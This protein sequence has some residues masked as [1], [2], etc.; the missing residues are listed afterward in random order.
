MRAGF[1]CAWMEEF[2]CC[3]MTSNFTAF[4]IIC[5]LVGVK[6]YEECAENGA[7][8][9]HNANISGVLSICYNSTWRLVCDDEWDTFDA[10][11]VCKQLGLEYEDETPK[12]CPARG[13]NVTGS[14]LMNRVMCLGTE[15]S[16][17]MCE[18][19]HDVTDCVDEEAVVVECKDVCNCAE[20]AECVNNNGN[21]SCICK[22]G[23]S[24][25]GTVCKD[26]N[27]CVLEIHNCAE[28]AKCI[29]TPGSF[30]CMC[31]YGYV[32]NGTHCESCDPDNSPIGFTGNGTYCEDI[33]E[34]DLGTH[35]CDEN[36][37]CTNVPGSFL[38]VCNNGYVGDGTF[39]IDSLIRLA[40]NATSGFVEVYYN[41]EWRS[42]CDDY[43]SYNDAN[44]ACGQLGFLPFC[45]DA[46]TKGSFKPGE[47]AKY[48][49]DDVQC[50]GDEK[51]LFDCPHN[52]VATHNCGPK[53]RAGVHCLTEDDI[54]I[55]LM[56]NDTSGI[57]EVRIR[58]EWRAVCDNAWSD[59]DAKVACRELGF[60]F[61]DAKAS[62]GGHGEGVYWLN[63]VKC[64]G[65]EESLFACSHSGKGVHNCGP[66]KRAGVICEASSTSI[67]LRQRKQV[68]TDGECEVGS[69]RLV[70]EDFSSWRVGEG[71]VE[72][73]VMGRW[74]AVCDDGWDMNATMVVCREH[75]M[76]TEETVPIRR[77]YQSRN[78]SLVHYW[79]DDIQ[80]NGDEESLLDCQHAALGS[81]DCGYND[82][83]SV[84]CQG[85]AGNET[86]AVKGT[87]IVGDHKHGYEDITD[88]AIGGVANVVGDEISGTVLFK[89][90]QVEDGTVFMVDVDILGLDARERYTWGIHNGTGD[91]TCEEDVEIYD[92]TSAIAKSCN[93]KKDCNMDS[94]EKCAVGDYSGRFGT[95][96]G[97][98]R[99]R[100]NTT[101]YVGLKM[102]LRSNFSMFIRGGGRKICEKIAPDYECDEGDIVMTFVAN[103]LLMGPIEICV[104][105]KW[106]RVCDSNWSRSDA[107]VACRQLGLDT[108]D[109][110]QA[111]YFNEAEVLPTEVERNVTDGFECSGNE[112]FSG[113]CEQNKTSRPR[114]KY[115]KIVGVLCPEI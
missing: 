46:T 2:K 98:G 103:V 28:D 22:H 12:G 24:G 107:V 75:G 69:T 76:L 20:M 49:L 88:Y 27:E 99:K 65:H 113:G 31:K 86:V 13:L 70:R 18:H 55:R 26:I 37:N 5:L 108:S 3:K 48:W 1:V 95:L 60:P 68:S 114:G 38:C 111:V 11:F 50:L 14:F 104:H 110:V 36:A 102:L 79:L 78:V 62:T 85:S 101:G 77:R 66:N 6:S 52:K 74:R 43:W 115:E 97:S 106:H 30:S 19:S 44:V 21:Y 35:N 100:V 90:V 93:Y 23:Y 33:D 91:M 72:I 73:C 51:S 39:C 4:L 25:N 34:C 57:I 67:Q 80:C 94:P 84:A 105:R 96:D 17:L 56:V 32:G 58:G 92:P 40:G 87:K 8:Q 45:A 9:L 54:G 59:V 15:D 83:A 63:R 64:E 81:H 71:F 47:P 82:R 53:E 109:R 10:E 89:P 29:N 112:S 41:G 61:D 42:V 16:L 7:L